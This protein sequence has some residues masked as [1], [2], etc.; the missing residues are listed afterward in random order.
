M[1]QIRVLCYLES[2]FLSVGCGHLSYLDV[3]E[4]RT[5]RATAIDARIQLKSIVLDVLSTHFWT[6]TN[7]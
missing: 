4:G 3:L 7:C 2:W 6:L 5:V 1:A